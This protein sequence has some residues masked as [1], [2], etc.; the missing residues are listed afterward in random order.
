MNYINK[1]SFTCF[2]SVSCRFRTRQF[3]EE[4]IGYCKAM[5]LYFAFTL[6]KTVYPMTRDFYL[7]ESHE[8]EKEE[9]LK[10]VSESIL[11]KDAIKTK[12]NIK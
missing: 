4:N 6:Q 10:E 7:C 12:E 11:L 9:K 1:H 5:P 8:F 3:K 2:V